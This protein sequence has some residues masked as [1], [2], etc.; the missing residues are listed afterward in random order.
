[1]DR[2]SKI[3]YQWME[4]HLLVRPQTLPLSEALL[5]K[6]KNY[7]MLEELFREMGGV[8]A[9]IYVPKE[10]TLWTANRKALL[11]DTPLD[12]NRYRMQTYRSKWYG[13]KMPELDAKAF[14]R[15]CRQKEKECLK[16]GLGPEQWTNK[17]AEQYFGKAATGG[18]FFGN[19][20]PAWK[21]RAW[22]ALLT[23]VAA[24]GH[25]YNLQ[26]VSI[27]QSVMMDKKL[28]PLGS[29]LLLGKEV[30]AEKIAKL[31]KRGWGESN[32][33]PAPDDLFKI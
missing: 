6:W 23:D 25:F 14:A 13:E 33:A 21:L 20:A 18:D 22:T 32:P 26:R 4:E 5:R 1:M 2:S 24:H 15:N 31:V 9:R 7:E 11:I 29:I 8:S 16:L 30:H 12:Y 10:I 19:G 17:L 28:Q 3:F 27:Y